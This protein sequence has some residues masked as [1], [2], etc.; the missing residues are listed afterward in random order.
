MA[1]CAAIAGFACAART[2]RPTSAPADSLVARVEAYWKRREAKDLAGAYT[3]YCSGYQT[4]VSRAEFLGFTRL[5]RFDIRDV[6]VAPVV[7][8]ANRV[9]VTV[10]FR[11]IAPALSQEPIES[12]TKEWW[13]REAG[14]QWCKEDE[15]LVLPFPRSPGL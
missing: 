11:F 8:A 3:F 13:T 4:R 2:E 10:S 12:Q 14:R 6:H 7:E 15:P 9:E 1:V 5:T